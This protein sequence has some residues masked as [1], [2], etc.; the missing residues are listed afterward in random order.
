MSPN[1][2]RVK[3]VPLKEEFWR[4]EVESFTLCY[5]TRRARER[6]QSSDLFII[7]VFTIHHSI[8]EV[9]SAGACVSF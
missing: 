3:E 2:R 5:M 7:V 9:I 4:N 1:G 8:Y 6:P